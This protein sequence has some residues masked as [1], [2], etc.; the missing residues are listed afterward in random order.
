M[1]SLR[2]RKESPVNH[3]PWFGEVCPVSKLRNES[4]RRRGGVQ[5]NASICVETTFLSPKVRK[6]IF[7]PIRIAIRIITVTMTL[8]L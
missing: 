7:D 6:A 8:L 3:L 4:W 1:D 5:G 2:M